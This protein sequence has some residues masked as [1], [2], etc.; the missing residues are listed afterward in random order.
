MKDRLK[1]GVQSDSAG[2]GFKALKDSFM[3]QEQSIKI[4]DQA[5]FLKKGSMAGEVGRAGLELS[6]IHI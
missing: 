4:K 6:L 5:L 3:Q 2:K 1:G